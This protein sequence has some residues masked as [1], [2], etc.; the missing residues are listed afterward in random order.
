M[1]ET[2]YQSLREALKRWRSFEECLLVDVRFVDFGF[3]VDL[4]FNYV[5]NNGSGVR[6][7]VLESPQLVA[8]HLIGVESLRFQGGLTPGMKENPENVDWGLTEISIVRS[9]ETEA[10][11][12]L[13][14]VW[15]GKRRLDVEFFAFRMISGSAVHPAPRGAG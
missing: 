15:E 13:S 3:G 14:V 12:G 11:L 5:W 1:N 2:E 9:F 10:G 8:C 6:K 4:I 7:D